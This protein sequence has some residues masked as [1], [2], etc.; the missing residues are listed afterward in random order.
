[1]ACVLPGDVDDLLEGG[2]HDCW[3]WHQLLDLRYME[4]DESLLSLGA[5]EESVMSARMANTFG[6]AKV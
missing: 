6:S 1:M 3:W 2:D 4:P 5:S